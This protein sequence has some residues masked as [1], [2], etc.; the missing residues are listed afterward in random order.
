MSIH[1]LESGNEEFLEKCPVCDNGYMV[2][3]TGH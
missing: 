3:T 1:M 2:P